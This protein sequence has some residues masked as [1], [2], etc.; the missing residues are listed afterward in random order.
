MAEKILNGRLINKHDVEANWLQAT[1]FVPNKA[2]IIVYDT[3]E[4]HAKERIK[5]GN[6]ITPVNEL[7]FITESPIAADEIDRICGVTT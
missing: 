2:E 3:D 5:I 7:P 6:G 1:S 4:N